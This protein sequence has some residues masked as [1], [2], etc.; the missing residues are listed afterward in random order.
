MILNLIYFV[1]SPIIRTFALC[2]CFPLSRMN[3]ESEK[4]PRLLEWCRANGVQIDPRVSIVQNPATGDI[5]VYNTSVEYISNSTTLVT[6]PKS[7]ILSIRSCSLSQI[8]AG[9]FH[10]RGIGI[11]PYGHEAKLALAL[12]LYSELL[13][14]YASRWEGYLQ[15]LP[16]QIVPIALFWGYEYEDEPSSADMAR[17]EMRS[18]IVGTELERGFKNRETGCDVLASVLLVDIFSPGY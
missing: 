9:A 7:S 14:K 15:S 11:P 10:S 12:A 2:I 1:C 6:I 18:W 16:L 13:W 8:L 5:T 3:L 17:F 4:V